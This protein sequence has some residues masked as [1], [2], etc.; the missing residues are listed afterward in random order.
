MGSRNKKGFTLVE[1][2]IVVAIIGILSAI[3]IPAML[4]AAEKAR[5]RRFAREIQAAGHAF[6]RFSFDH[7]EYPADRT[8]AQMPD[9]MAEY[10][11]GFPWTE[12]TV[13]G[14]SWDWDSGQF[15]TLAGVSVYLPDWTDSRMMEI[16]RVIDDGNLATGQFRKRASG[17]IYV[18]E[19]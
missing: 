5:A 1:I 12:E 18:L 15:S 6:V 10:L 8:P 4:R 19:E 7:G 13:I 9:G 2:M 14:G 16:D 17:Y 11:T 3:S